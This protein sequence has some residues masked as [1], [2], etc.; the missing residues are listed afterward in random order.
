MEDLL[1]RP[2][3]TPSGTTSPSVVDLRPPERLIVP[4]YSTRLRSPPVRPAGTGGGFSTGSSPGAISTPFFLVTLAALAL[5]LHGR[6]LWTSYWGDEAI[7]VGIAAHPLSSLPHYLVDD[8]SPPLYY[9]A[10]HYW[11]KIVRAVRGGDPRPL[12][13]PRPA[14]HTGGLVVRGQA[15]RS[16]G[17]PGGGRTGGHVRLPGLLQHRDPDVL[18]AGAGGPSGR[19]LL[20]PRLPGAPAGATGWRRRCSWPPSS[21][22]STTACTSSP[23][24]SSSARP[25]PPAGGPGRSCGRRGFTEAPAPSSSPPGCPSSFTSSATRAPRGL[26]TPPCSTSSGTRSTPWPRRPGPPSSSPWSSPCFPVSAG[27]AGRRHGYR[28]RHV[29][30]SSPGV[31]ALALFTA[32]TLVT[33]VLAWLVGQVVNSWDPR[34]LGIAVVPALVPLAGGLAR[35]RGGRGSPD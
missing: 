1:T 8:G 24:P 32:V 21:I 3:P 13:G 34:Y 17:G 11:M 9:V 30:P 4:L 20:R 2:A 5:V 28:A 6:T 22:S 10:L 7:A 33:L 31:S 23:P 25:W 19:H 29:P 12:A 16:L 15:L 27:A 26:P 14:R 35:A 18:V